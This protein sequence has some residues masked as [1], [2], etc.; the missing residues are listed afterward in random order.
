MSKTIR[1]VILIAIITL[2]TNGCGGENAQRHLDLG[3]W[4]FEKALVDDAV[5]EYKEAIRL[6]P[7]DARRLTQEELNIVATAHRSLAV[8]YASKNWFELAQAEAQITFELQ[9]TE[10][11]YKLLN[12]VRQRAQLETLSGANSPSPY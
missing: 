11:N 1:T 8:A 2:L 4:Y 12:L 7:A 9:P 3:L 10:A 5:L 6:L